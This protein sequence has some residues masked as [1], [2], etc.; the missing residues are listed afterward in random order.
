MPCEPHPHHSNLQVADFL[1]C[2]YP[3]RSYLCKKI[4]KTTPSIF[5]DCLRNNEKLPSLSLPLNLNLNYENLLFSLQRYYKKCKYANF[6]GKNMLFCLKTYYFSSKSAL[7][8]NFPFNV[9]ALASSI[10]TITN[11]PIFLPSRGKT[12]VLY[13]EV[14]PY[15]SSLLRFE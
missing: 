13:C 5:C 4:M 9:A 2:F 7:Y 8:T 12:T 10:F 6:L 1:V 3:I 11:S 15:I 14:L